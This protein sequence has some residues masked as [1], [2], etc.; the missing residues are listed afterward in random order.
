MADVTERCPKPAVIMK[1]ITILSESVKPYWIFL[2]FGSYTLSPSFCRKA[3]N[4]IDTFLSFGSYTLS[5]S[6][7][8][9]ASK[10]TDSFLSFGSYALS[11]LSLPLCRKA[12]KFTDTSRCSVHAHCLYHSVG[13]LRSLLT[14]SVV[15]F[16][17]TVSTIL[18][19]SF[20]SYW[21]FL[22]FGSCTLS[23]SFC[24]K[25]SKL[26]DTP[27]CSVHTH[28]LD[29]SIGKLQ[30]LLTLFYRLVHTHCLCCLYHCVGKLQSL[31]TLLIVWFIHT[32]SIIL[33]ESFKA[34][35]HFS[36]FGS[37]TLSLPFCRKAS[38][39][40]DTS[41]CSVHTHCSSSHQSYHQSYHQTYLP[42]WR[43]KEK[44]KKSV[45]SIVAF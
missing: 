5:P 34:Y 23:L 16:A 25:A 18:S 39:L 9:K 21:Y 32:V 44:E 37:C 28:C 36:L 38:K 2:S 11:L 4:F 43:K 40:I 24:R 20:K 45:V 6:L 15:W 12:S 10:L 19:E 42:S 1:P 13:K 22:S 17:H 27:Y 7:C 26:T 33:S 30:S 14:L 31:L 8:R 29:H 41:Y 3:S 35:W